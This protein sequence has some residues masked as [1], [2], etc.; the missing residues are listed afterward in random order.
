M[1]KLYEQDT[2]HDKNLVGDQARTYKLE[3]LRE[4]SVLDFSRLIIEDQTTETKRKSMPKRKGK[5]TID[6]TSKTLPLMK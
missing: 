3:S 2:I 4:L 6:V 1:I 5:K